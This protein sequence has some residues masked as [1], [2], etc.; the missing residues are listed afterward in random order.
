MRV[1]L[2]GNPNVGKSALFSRLTGSHVVVSNYSGTTVE[3]THGTMKLDAGLYPESGSFPESEPFPG[4]NSFP[5]SESIP[6]SE[7]FPGSGSIEITDVPGTYSLQPGNRAEEVASHMISEGDIIINVLDATSLERSLFLCIQLIKT[8]KPVIIALNMWD[9]AQKKGIQIDPQKMEEM[10]GVPVVPTCALNG[11]GISLLKKRLPEAKKGCI[12]QGFQ[13]DAQIG[14]KP[15]PGAETADLSIDSSESLWQLASELSGRLQSKPDGERSSNSQHIDHLTVHPILG[16]IFALCILFISFAFVAWGGDILHGILGT[17]FEAAWLPLAVII[18]DGLGQ[19]GL[20][21][22]I[23]IGEL[24]GGQILLE[25]SFGLLTTGLYIPLAVVLPYIF[26][27]YCVL[28]ILEDIGYLPRMGVVVDAFMQRLGIHGLSV[29]PMMLGVGCNVP[30]VMAGRML[31]TRKER[32]IVA[33]LIAVVVP[34]MAQQAMVIGLL[35]QA[36]ITGLAIVY[37]TLFLLWMMMGFLMNFFI[38]GES[39]QILIDLPPY[40]LPYWESL[41]KKIYMRMGGFMKSAL[42]YVLLG[43]FIVNL[44]YTFGIIDF[45]SI[46]FAPVITGLFG[47]PGEAGGALVIGFLRKDVAVGMLAP[48]GLQLNQLIVASV[49]L[50]VYFPCIATFVVLFKELGTLDLIKLTLIMLMVVLATGTGLHHL[51]MLTGI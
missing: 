6:L 27:F 39:P 21:H 3:Y 20:V 47:L 1:L 23:L 28:S 5:G 45:I 13:V 4:S 12:I 33:T 43:V 49:V 34:C 38:R 25:E 11:D 10:L 29:V 51:L 14:S 2:M 16:P 48:L 15:G 7:P 26:C 17:V 41:I 24:I 18:S 22:N 50:M 36:G 40:R 9:E 31:E 44:M 35:G 19:S 32:F 42:P 46:V 37:G 8:G 30:G